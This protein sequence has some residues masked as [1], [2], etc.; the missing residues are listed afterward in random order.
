MTRSTVIALLATLLTLP[1]NAN[2]Q[3]QPAMPMHVERTA[4]YTF[5]LDIGPSEEMAPDVMADEGM[6]VNHHLEL[7]IMHADDNMLVTDVTPIIRITDKSSGVSRDLPHVMGMTDPEMGMGD[8]HYGQNLFLPDGTYLVTV[9]VGSDTAQFRDVQVA[10]SPMMA[11]D[12]SMGQ[13]HEMAMAPG[14]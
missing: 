3:S 5:T 1:L 9:M 4:N 7:H 14:T 8:F 13:S 11:N 12:N 10:A 6:A 2:A